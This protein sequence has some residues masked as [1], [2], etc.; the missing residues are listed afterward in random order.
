MN[1]RSNL[2]IASPKEAEH[3]KTAKESIDP[4]IADLHVPPHSVEAEQSLLG[5]LLL[6]NL[7]LDRVTEIISAEDF[8]RGDHRLIYST[9]LQINEDKQPADV[10]TVYDALRLGG[11]EERVGGLS[12]LNTLA[13]NTPSTSHILAYAELIRER[14]L[15]RQLLGAANTIAQSVHEREQKKARILLDEAEQVIFEIA[16]KASRQAAGLSPIQPVIKRVTDII[17][18]LK[19]DNNPIT[20]QSTGF[21]DLDKNTAG[22]QPGDL[23]VLAARPS[24]GKTALAINIAQNIASVD[25]TGGIVA[26]FSMEMSSEQLVMR[27]MSSATEINLARLRSGQLTE[28]D[29]IKYHKSL[30]KTDQCKIFIDESSNLTALDVRTR[31]RRLYRTFGA[32]HLIVIDYLQLMAGSSSSGREENRTTELS[33]ISRSLK[34]LAKELKVP[35][36]ALS[37]LN[38][39]SERD[40]RAPIMS[41]LRDSGA[42]EQD[43]DLIMFLH[44]PKNDKE[45]QNSI[46]VG[47]AQLIIAKHRN[48]PTGTINLAFRK[49][50]ATFA[51][52]ANEGM[53]SEPY[54]EEST[55]HSSSSTKKKSTTANESSGL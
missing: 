23:I 45:I 3:V 2:S 27:M 16:D 5:A 24:M 26:I 14:S 21:I 13:T 11:Q 38:R 54:I 17:H 18:K 30:E 48:G 1:A 43:A 6:D 47:Q 10:I 36:I 28:N 19:K 41:D 46:P 32:L 15:L 44:R 29:F 4:A 37:Q 8:Y 25:T 35:I 9:I 55:Y 52:A 50:Y 20:G 12:Y 40:G 31:A 33:Q 34:S 7:N 39:S 53:N 22:L 49:E 51:N 42:I